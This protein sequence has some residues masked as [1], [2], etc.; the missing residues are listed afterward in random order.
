M[1]RHREVI[2]YR[3]KITWQSSVYLTGDGN[4]DL[5]RW[6]NLTSIDFAR[7]FFPS[8]FFREKVRKSVRDVRLY[9]RNYLIDS[10]RVVRL[11]N[12]RSSYQVSSDNRTIVGKF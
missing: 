11:K 2:R 1:L 12:K 10:I 8:L 7:Y 9:Q 6:I 4:L 3:A 5:D